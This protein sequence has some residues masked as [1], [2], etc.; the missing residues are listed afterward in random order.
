ME[1]EVWDWS[2]NPRPSGK[3]CIGKTCKG[4]RRLQGLVRMRTY[5]SFL[6]PLLPN[7]GIVL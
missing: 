5:D 2:K 7:F 6:S 3:V 4:G 1:R